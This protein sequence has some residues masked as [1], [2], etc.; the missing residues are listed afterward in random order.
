ML[1][2]Q[3]S[4]AIPK[5]VCITIPLDNYQNIKRLFQTSFCPPRDEIT[6]NLSPLYKWGLFNSGAVIDRGRFLLPSRKSKG[7]EFMQCYAVLS[8]H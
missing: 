7:S 1:S 2:H 5:T 8:A 6:C 4:M 3:T